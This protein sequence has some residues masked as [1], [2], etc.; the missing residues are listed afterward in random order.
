[1]KLNKSLNPTKLLLTV[2]A[3]WGLASVASMLYNRVNGVTSNPD[4]K[5]FVAK[6]EAH[7]K[8]ATPPDEQGNFS[9]HCTA[10][11]V[12]DYYALT[13]NHCVVVTRRG[14]EIPMEKLIFVDSNGDKHPVTPVIS[15]RGSVDLAAV[16]GD[17]RNFKHYKINPYELGFEMGDDISICGYPWGI[18]N[19]SCFDGQALHVSI[20]GVV[21]YKLIG[22]MAPHMSGGPV[23]HDN[24]VVGVNIMFD[25]DNTYMTPLLGA[26]QILETI[27]N[28]E[29][30]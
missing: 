20:L 6:P 26:E 17:F 28:P 1:M 16:H 14:R 12:S 4:P 10:F 30:Y 9:T 21:A 24:Q 15:K 13:A 11:V 2:L 19:F 8:L 7:G 3:A 25:E 27:L 29:G 22:Y 23:F 5:N 18:P